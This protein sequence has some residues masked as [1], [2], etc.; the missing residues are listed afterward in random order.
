MDCATDVMIT[1]SNVSYHID[2][3]DREIR[4]GWAIWMV[5]P[6][7]LIPGYSYSATVALATVLPQGHPF[8]RVSCCAGTYSCNACSADSYSCDMR[9]DDEGERSRHIAGKVRVR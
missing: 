8:L 5:F 3:N 2:A 9:D 1:F 6:W 4:I 7:H